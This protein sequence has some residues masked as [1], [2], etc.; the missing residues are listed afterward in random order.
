MVP[1][2]SPR[3][4]RAAEIAAALAAGERPRAPDPGP[5]K[6]RVT[7]GD[8]QAPLATV[9]AVLD[10]NDLLGTDGW[11]R[12]D[13]AVVS[14]GDHFDWGAPADRA[15]ATADGYAILAYFAAQPQVTLLAGNHDLSRVGELAELDD[16]T[17]AA[18]RDAATALYRGGQTDPDDE[19]AFLA[20]YPAFPSVEVAARDLSCFDTPQRAL[21]T[22]LLR[23]RRLRLAC[24]A[25]PHQ[26]V[27]HAGVTDA[28][29]DALAAHA[30]DRADALAVAAAL[31]DALD[32][33]VDAWTSGPLAVPHLHQPGDA[34]RA[35]G[36]GALF[37][38][39]T[40]PDLDA[41][42]AFSGTRRRR[43]DPRTLPRGLTQVIGHVRDHKCRSLLGP[44]GDDA[45]PRDG[46]LRHLRTD[47][48]RVTYAHGLPASPDRDAATVLF[49]DAGML[50][51]QP[52]RYAL[53]DLG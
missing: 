23:D 14:V 43:Y 41:P 37:H 46:V 6:R 39:A 16:E 29:L 40:H 47:G 9:L 24:A 12:P 17:Y 35:E 28:E 53:L 8:P 10:A 3:T 2:P 44:W 26:L 38:R 13:V 30:A 25:G 50:H 36:G 7:L 27:V 20:R 32:R 21:V 18:A 45:P 51:V 34:A 19:A 11:I 33:A 42:T 15:Q 4:E 31:N 52:D 1:L 22:R 5:A 48:R 49:V